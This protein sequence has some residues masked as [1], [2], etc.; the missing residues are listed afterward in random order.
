MTK[1]NSRQEEFL[2]NL[3]EETK[4]EIRE[5]ELNPVGYNTELYQT[6]YQEIFGNDAVDEG[7]ETSL[8]TIV[9]LLWHRAI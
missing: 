9:D 3:S 4:Q 8:K 1:L 7:I 6:V 5:A 2:N